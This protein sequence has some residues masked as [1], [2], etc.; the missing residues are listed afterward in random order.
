MG[1]G[2]YVV[3]SKWARDP[4]INRMI[5]SENQLDWICITIGDRVPVYYM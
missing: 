5:R 3:S 1:S 2:D 4:D